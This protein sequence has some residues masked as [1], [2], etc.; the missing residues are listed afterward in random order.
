VRDAGDVKLL[1]GIVHVVDHRQEQPVLSE[2]ELDLEH[3]GELV[4][5]F[6]GQVRNALG[7]PAAGAANFK[8]AGTR[9]RELCA[10]ALAQPERF[11]LLSQEL[12]RLLFDAMGKDLRISP[13]SLAVCLYEGSSYPGESFVAL[14]KI[15]PSLMLQQ[16][17]VELPAGRQV[18]FDLLDNVMPA[19]RERLHKAALVRQPGKGEYQLLLLDRQTERLAATFFAEGFLGAQPKLDEVEHTRALYFGLHAAQERVLDEGLLPEAQAEWFRN[20]IESAVGGKRFDLDRWLAQLPVPDGAAKVIGGE[21]E[22]KLGDDRAFTL[23]P[24]LAGQLTE[25]RRLRGDFGLRFEVD[26]AHYG[27]VVREEKRLAGGVLRLVL[28]VRN[29]RWAP[30]RSRQAGAIVAARAAGG[31]AGS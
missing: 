27:D 6:E 16:K 26:S 19:A 18:T 30:V 11:V 12:A 25:K 3:H 21:L 5:Y 10:S 28:E 17:V 15:D 29:P 22:K 8:A 24:E 1:R 31:A 4:S 9:A 14:L 13:G 23:S 2:L 7:D 20:E